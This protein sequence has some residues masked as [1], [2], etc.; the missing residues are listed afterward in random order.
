MPEI[1]EVETVRKTLKRMILNKR[2]ENVDVI[3]ARII[4]NSTDEFKQ[5]LKGH[6][7]IDIERIGKWLLF[8]LSEY[9]LL[10]HLRMEGKFFV[11]NKKDAIVKHE[12][13]IITFEDQTTLRYHD[14]RKF[15][16]M[17]LVKKENL[18]EVE[19]IKKQGIEPI[20]KDLTKEYLYKC[21][22]NKNTP[23]KT[24]LLDQTIISGLGNIYANEVLFG[25]KI[26]PE[27]KGKDITLNDVSYTHLR[28]HETRQDRGCRGVRE[29]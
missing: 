4:E 26:H 28:A 15:G 18:Y 14:T 12:H 6:S 29:K 19:A 23:M 22:Q 3:Y 11:K 7:I 27:E 24:L 20:S 10:C 21:F 1:A 5:K 16:R 25:A 17:R 13:I 2:I 8:D 9:Y